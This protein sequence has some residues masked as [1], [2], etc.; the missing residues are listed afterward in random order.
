MCVCRYGSVGTFPFDATNR[1]VRRISH[2]RHRA[3]SHNRAKSLP[4]LRS[5]AS[6]PSIAWYNNIQPRLNRVYLV[7]KECS[8]LMC[9]SREKELYMC[10]IWGYRIDVLTRIYL[11]GCFVRWAVIAGGSVFGVN[12]AGVFVVL[13]VMMMCMVF[14]WCCCCYFC[15]L[16]D[17][18]RKASRSQPP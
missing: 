3:S 14:I 6:T 5:K 4:P 9:G 15:V 2:H 13:L 1:T 16:L 8:I 12:G 10:V 17:E 18:K 11:V 7:H